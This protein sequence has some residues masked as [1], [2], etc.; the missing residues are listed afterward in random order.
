MAGP[1]P[2]TDSDEGQGV[3]EDERPRARGNPP[4]HFHPTDNVMETVCGALQAAGRDATLCVSP[5]GPQTIPY[6][7]RGDRAYICRCMLSPSRILV[8][9][10]QARRVS[11]ASEC[12]CR[13]HPKSTSSWCSRTSRSPVR[14]VVSSGAP[15]RARYF[16][17]RH[18]P[19]VR[20]RSVGPSNDAARSRASR[21]DVPARGDSPSGLSVSP[22]RFRIDGSSSTTR[23]VGVGEPALSNENGRSG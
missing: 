9:D 22:T 17:S 8:G 15:E 18:F 13:G 21:P 12:L 5:Q 11:G 1:D 7:V 14:P 4:A 20:S 19:S 3:R 6:C 23:I 16:H 2:G 10:R